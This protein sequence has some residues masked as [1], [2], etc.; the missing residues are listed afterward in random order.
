[1]FKKWRQTSEKCS[2]VLVQLATSTVQFLLNLFV[3]FQIYKNKK[4]FFV[5]TFREKKKQ[6]KLLIKSELLTCIHKGAKQNY[7]FCPT[8]QNKVEKV[9]WDKNDQILRC[10]FFF[11]FLHEL[12]S[13]R[14]GG[15]KLATPCTFL[16]NV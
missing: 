1:M 14:H 13:G 8:W 4:L 6:A 16:T 11:L 7:S 3:F 10:L 5:T 15:W 9:L 2:F 12:K